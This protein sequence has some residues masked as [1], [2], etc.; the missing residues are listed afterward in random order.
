MTLPTWTREPL[1][2][3]LFA[4][5]LVFAFF[6]IRGGGEVDPAGRTISID[7]ATK[8]QISGGFER[9]MGRAPTDTE[10]DTEIARYVREEVLYRE[11]LRLGLDGDDAIVRRRL[12]QKMDLLASARAE[13]EQ[14]GEA[15]LREWYAK[16]P[17]RFAEDRAY[18]FDQI[19]FAKENEAQSGLAQLRGSSDWRQLAGGISLPD[20]VETMP[21]GEVLERFGTQFIDEL[22]K[23]QPDELWQG[24]LPS[25]FGWHVIRLHSIAPSKVPPFDR[26]REDV[27]KD[28]R[29]ATID[30]RREQAYRILRDSYRIEIAR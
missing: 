12:A 28:W 8:A 1:V 15:A 21:R 16:H 17:E 2:H 26:I 24:P 30:Q 6:S 11:A 5:A 9:L 4:G 23:L 14:P 18:S 13:T 27:E 19:W 25:G 29:S 7:R 20:T 10:L 3:F 22:D